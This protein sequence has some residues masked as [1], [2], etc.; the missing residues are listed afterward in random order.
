[1]TASQRGSRARARLS[2]ALQ[3]YLFAALAVLLF[4]IHSFREGRRHGS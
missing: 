2:Y 4:V 3:W 1:M